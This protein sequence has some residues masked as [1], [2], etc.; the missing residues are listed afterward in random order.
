M[1][2]RRAD[3]GGGSDF[4]FETIKRVKFDAADLSGVRVGRLGGVV[5]LHA[6][7]DLV[8]EAAAGEVTDGVHGA[9]LLQLILHDTQ[10][11]GLRLRG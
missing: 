10:H 2:S 5:D 6:P 7:E 3:C 4:D 9:L 1:I 11:C 8:L